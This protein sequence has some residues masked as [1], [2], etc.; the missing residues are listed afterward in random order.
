MYDC[1]Y[2]PKKEYYHG[3][4]DKEVFIYSVAYVYTAHGKVPESFRPI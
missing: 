1:V 3:I 2:L 4:D